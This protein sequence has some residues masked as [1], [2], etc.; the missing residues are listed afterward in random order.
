MEVS[1]NQCPN[2]LFP[3]NTK[4]PAWA[5]KFIVNLFKPGGFFL[6]NKTVSNYLEKE[7]WISEQM[8]QPGEG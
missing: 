4:Y 6:K 8:G 3:V 2:L 7:A 5:Q 1:T